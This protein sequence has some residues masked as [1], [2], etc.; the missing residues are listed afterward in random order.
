MIFLLGG[1]CMVSRRVRLSD[2]ISCIKVECHFD[3]YL[4]LLVRLKFAGVFAHPRVKIVKIWSDSDDRHRPVHNKIHFDY[5]N[6][7][8]SSTSF[9][10][11]VVVLGSDKKGNR[12]RPTSI[13]IDLISTLHVRSKLAERQR[14]WM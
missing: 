2:D 14:R 12:L 9:C 13:S 6:L 11:L 1:I 5:A 8:S 10:I 3:A 4:Q 7:C